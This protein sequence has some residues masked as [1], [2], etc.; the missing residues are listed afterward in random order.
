MLCYD[1]AGTCGLFGWTLRTP[2]L[3][4]DGAQA[5]I[6]AVRLERPAASR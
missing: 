1:L 6:G 2:P 3:A 4:P 5:A